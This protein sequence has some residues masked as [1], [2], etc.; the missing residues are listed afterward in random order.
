MFFDDEIYNMRVKYN[1]KGVVKTRFGKIDVIKLSPVLP[2]N[3]MFKGE[4]AIRIWVSDDR[5]RVPIR[6]ELEFPVGSASMEIKG[7]K[8]TR[9]NFEWR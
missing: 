9:Y 8:N 3:E 4:N 5:N 2:Q 7:Y 6:I 1:G